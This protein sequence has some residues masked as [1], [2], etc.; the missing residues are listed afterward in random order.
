MKLPLIA[1]LLLTGL[2]RQPLQ[3][4]TQPTSAKAPARRSSSRPTPKTSS[5]PTPSATRT[6]LSRQK[7]GT[8]T[9]TALPSGSASENRVVPG[10]PPPPVRTVNTP[11]ATRQHSTVLPG[12][13]VTE[14]PKPVATSS[15]REVI[16]HTPVRYSGRTGYQKGD[17]LVN[18]G[19]G[20]SS[21]YYGNPV[22]ISFE[23]GL[24]KDI[25]A[26]VQLDYNSGNYGDYYYSSSRWRYTATYIGI[27][28]SYHVNRVFRLNTEKVDLYAG[29][30]LGYR[31]FRWHDANYG[32]GYDYRSGAFFNYF[33]GGKYYFTPKIGAFAEFGY[34]GLSSAR[35]GLTARF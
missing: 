9:S 24:D 7:T 29:L 33:I 10:P 11:S 18:L 19:I 17:Q 22:G 13:A 5:T 3:A 6:S 25:S 21:Y 4:Q 16:S 23:T 20:L 1:F 8:P 12:E 2:I 32:Y 14:T 31:S 15:R 34:T 27:R 30:G 26:G 35:V 28:G